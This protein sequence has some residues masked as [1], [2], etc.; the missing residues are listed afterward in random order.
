[1]RERIK[2]LQDMLTPTIK[3]GPLGSVW[4]NSKQINLVWHLPGY[5][6]SYKKRGKDARLGPFGGGWAWQVGV[7]YATNPSQWYIMLKTFSI[8]VTRR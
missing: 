8:S 2:R 4:D 7:Q 6:I 3:S 5:E 1:M